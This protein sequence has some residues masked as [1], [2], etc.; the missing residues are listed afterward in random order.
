MKDGRIVDLDGISNLVFDVHITNNL[1]V[2]VHHRNHLS[3]MSSLAL[4]ETANVYNYNFSNALP[5][6][7]NVGHKH[8]GNG[9]FG[10]RGGDGSPNGNIDAVDKTDVWK[11]QTGDAGYNEGDFNLNKQVANP[12]KNQIWKPNLNTSTQVPN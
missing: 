7:Y 1:H 3:V 4:T 8:L 12:D 2:V 6:A 11:V 10:M 9:I 5:K